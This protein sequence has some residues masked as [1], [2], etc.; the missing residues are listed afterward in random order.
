[1]FPW[2][3]LGAVALAAAACFGGG[4]KV[5]DWQATEDDL[6]RE[7]AAAVQLAAIQRGM[8]LASAETEKRLAQAAR[9]LAATRG[10]SERVQ[11]LAASV[12]ASSEA[13][14]RDRERIRVLSELVASGARLLEEGE[15]L[16][17]RL[18]ARLAGC[19]AAP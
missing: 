5:R 16:A 18:D 7:R 2:L 15:G 12:R 13:S 19:Q 17:G 6:K 10:D 3:K 1:M 14:E 11:Q 9:T 4:Y 8:D